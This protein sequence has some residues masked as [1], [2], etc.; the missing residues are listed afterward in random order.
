LIGGT[1]FSCQD[2]SYLRLKNVEL[3]Y[4]ISS[5]VLKR[6]QVGINGIRIYANGNNLL[7]FTNF[8]RQLDPEGSSTSVYPMVRRFNIGTK[9]T[10]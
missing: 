3:S 10:F 7:T 8:N 2:A 5:S 1:T 4:D 9:V 6:L